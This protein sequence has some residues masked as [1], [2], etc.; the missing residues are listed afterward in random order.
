M[1]AYTEC[2]YICGSIL[3]NYLS[4]FYL[5]QFRLMQKNINRLSIFLLI[6]VFILIKNIIYIKNPKIFRKY[7]NNLQSWHGKRY[8]ERYHDINSTAFYWYLKITVSG[9]LEGRKF[10]KDRP[11]FFFKFKPRRSP[12]VS[13]MKRV[14]GFFSRARFRRYYHNS[15][16]IC[17]QATRET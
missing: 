7:I 12:F 16:L 11:Y 1:R 8:C 17:R 4:D 6:P 10:E 9:K 14:V 15:L 13:W 2:W 3:N 5:N